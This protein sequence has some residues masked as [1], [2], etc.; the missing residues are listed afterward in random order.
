MH[1]AHHDAVPTLRHW[2]NTVRCRLEDVMSASELRG[3]RLKSGVEKSRSNAMAMEEL[4]TWL[5]DM[6][7]HLAGKEAQ[8]LPENIPILE[9][10]KQDHAVCFMFHCYC[11]IIEIV[12]ILL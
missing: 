6:E 2:L 7:Q 3:R 1:M 10:L 5:G 11:C 4:S 8:A 12:V 9:Q